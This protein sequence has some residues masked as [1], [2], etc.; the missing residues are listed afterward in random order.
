MP[1]ALN[2][3][4][5]RTYTTLTCQQRAHLK[6]HGQPALIE[7]N[8]AAPKALKHLPGRKPPFW[9]VQGPMT[10][11]KNANQTIYCEIR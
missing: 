4:T 5:G 2:A 7:V 11:Y 10:P 1:S 3:V 8:L 9:A 6:V